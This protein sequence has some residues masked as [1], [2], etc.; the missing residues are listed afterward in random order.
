M[1]GKWLRPGRIVGAS[2]NRWV[3]LQLA[4]LGSAA[5]C[6]DGLGRVSGVV[7]LDGEKVIAGEAMICDVTFAPTEGGAAVATGSVDKWG[8]YRIA[9]GQNSGIQPGRYNVGV[10]VRGVESRN[11]TTGYPEVTIL[12]SPKHANPAT[13]GIVADVMTGENSIDLEVDGTSAK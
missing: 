8:T 6:S 7:R 4:L 11:G 12:S 13:S 10:I 2:A 3:I 9:T 5:G 1:Q